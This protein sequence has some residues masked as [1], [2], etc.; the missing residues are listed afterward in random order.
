MACLRLQAELPA[1][2]IDGR[3]NIYLSSVGQATLV[4]EIRD[5]ESNAVLVRI[6]DRRAAQNI[7]P[8][9]RSTSVTN[10]SEVQQLARTWAAQLRTGLDE[11]TTWDK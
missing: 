8:A 6:I 10:W 1:E 11:A 4:I 2:L 7:G 3:S 5:S 9:Q